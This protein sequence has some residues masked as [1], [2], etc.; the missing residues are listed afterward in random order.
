MALPI[1]NYSDGTKIAFEKIGPNIT[2][3]IIPGITLKSKNNDVNEFTKG[4]TQQASQASFSSDYG[5]I[6]SI[7]I[8]SYNGWRNYN[9]LANTEVTS[10]TNPPSS[11][12][13]DNQETEPTNSSITTDQSTNPIEDVINTPPSD[14]SSLPSALN[15]PPVS[16]NQS[17]SIPIKQL[18]KILGIDL[19]TKIKEFQ[20]K[21]GLSKAA[22]KDE[23][24]GTLDPNNVDNFNKFVGS[25]GGKGVVNQL[26]SIPTITT[27]GSTLNTSSLASF[28]DEKGSFSFPTKIEFG[29]VVGTV[30]DAKTNQLIP[31]V[32][33]KNPFLKKA[34]TDKYGFF[35]I[36]HP[37]IPPL[38]TELGIISPSQLPITLTTRGIK[39][40]ELKQT[41]KYVPQTIIPYTSTGELKG[42]VDI[43]DRAKSTGVG[44]VPLKRLE[45]DLRKQIIDYLKFPDN[46]VQEYTTKEATYDFTIQKL[47][48]NTIENLKGVIIP[49]L[50]TLIAIYG[51]SEV[52]QL[53]EDTK[54]KNDIKSKEAYKRLEEIITCPSKKEID[55][56]IATKN[57]LVGGIN[58]T[59]KVIERITSTLEVSGVIIEGINITYQALKFLPTPTAVAGVGI[60]IFVI[61]AVQD[62]KQFLTNNLGKIRHIN[63]TTLNILRLLEIALGQ[64]LDLLNLLDVITQFCY[65]ED[66]PSNINEELRAIT[67]EQSN[68]QSPIVTNVNGFTMGIEI[69]K[70]T[71]S[72]KRKRATA[73]N[74]Q[75]VVMLRGEYSFSSIEQILIDELVFYIQQNDLKAD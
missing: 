50:L 75:N 57:K 28:Q 65:P 25:T 18:L 53:I 43:K 73:T 21:Q 72:L 3:Y 54:N 67:T 16:E 12:G 56:I 52:K 2:A 29:T 60:P 26:G 46:A 23:F 33:V 11:L 14:R 20:E 47:T 38:L 62:V 30:V 9:G 24:T 64:V 74:N 41:I 1:Y 40:P 22:V 27:G 8:S 45:G 17:S 59:L 51:V 49:L 4:V 61:N 10:I 55:N 68:Q 48:N 15:P 58:N 39:D 69:E 44:K 6:A 31:G 32:K 35:E 37:I 36:K 66:E 7:T 70:T 42:Y 13:Q 71:N 63:A 5:N 34:T 19:D